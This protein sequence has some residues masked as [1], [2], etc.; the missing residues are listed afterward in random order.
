MKEGCKLINL[1]CELTSLVHLASNFEALNRAPWR[2]AFVK[3][4]DSCWL[5]FLFLSFLRRLL[6]RRRIHY[7]TGAI[8]PA[9][10]ESQFIVVNPSTSKSIRSKGGRAMISLCGGC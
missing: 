5:A 6:D 7:A 9:R 8:H 2:I 3:Q 10:I 1:P 4:V